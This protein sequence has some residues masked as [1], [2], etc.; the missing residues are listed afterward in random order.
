MEKQLSQPLFTWVCYCLAF[1]FLT[2]GIMKLV[3][4]DFKV[5]FAEL[6]LPFPELALFIVAIVEVACGMLIAKRFYLHLAVPPLIL[7][8][9]VALYLTKLPTLLHQGVLPFLFEARLDIVIF[10]LLLVIWKNK[11]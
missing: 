4:S 3:A 2:S 6:G 9:L 7:I 5:R 10:V 8:M 11:G 1:V